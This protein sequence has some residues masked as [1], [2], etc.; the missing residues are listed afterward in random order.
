[1]FTDI[2]G[3]TAL[4][5]K[6]EVTAVLWLEGHRKHF[7]SSMEKYGGKIV[8]FYGDGSLSIFESAVMAVKSAIELQQVWQKET[9]VP[10][11]IGMHVG[12]I[13]M[14]EDGIIGDA[15]NIASRIESLA[16][17]GSILISGRLNTELKNQKEIE[18]QWFGA[19]EFKNVEEPIEVFAVNAPGIINPEA[20]HPKAKLKTKNDARNF[21][22]YAHEF[23]GREKE[24]RELKA[25][26]L[27]SSHRL[28]TILGAGGLGKTRLA[29]EIGRIITNEFNDG[30][31]YVPLDGI[32]TDS[33]IYK[34]IGS[35]LGVREQDKADWRTKTVEFLKNLSVLLV[36]DNFEHLLAGKN[37]VKEI[38]DLCPYLKL[39]ITSR[40]NLNLAEE[41]EFHLH[42]FDVPEQKLATELNLISQNDSISLFIQ[43]A[44]QVRTNFVLDINNVNSIVMICRELEGVPLAI[45]LAA[46]RIK[47]FSPPQILHRLEDLF[48]LLKTSRTTNQK[49]HQ[50]IL[51]TIRWSY[52]LLTQEDQKVFRHFSVFNVGFSLDAAQALVPETD[53][54]EV[55][56]SLVN[57]S[58]LRID[59]SDPEETRFAML[60]VIREFGQKELALYPSEQAKAENA[61]TN[62]YLKFLTE[63]QLQGDTGKTSHWLML[64]DKEIEHIRYVSQYYLRNNDHRLRT[65]TLLHWRYFLLKGFLREGYE[66][67]NK[68]IMGNFADRLQGQLLVAMGAFS[69]NLG[70]F[71]DARSKF[72]H[73]LSIFIKEEDH[74]QTCITLNNLAWVEFRLGN[75]VK[76]NSYAHDALK[77]A[78]K[79]HREKHEATALNNYAWVEKFRGNPEGA[80]SLFNQV[81]TFQN[82]LENEH[83]QAFCMVNK[84]W[85]YIDLGQIEEAQSTIKPAIGY[86]HQVGDRQLWTFSKA[87]QSLLSENPISILVEEIIPSF[88]DIGD[89]W[90][91]GL[92]QQFLAN[93]FLNLQDFS[94]AENHIQKSLDI[95][96]SIDDRWG[97]CNCH[98]IKAIIYLN[99]QNHFE[100]RR[101]LNLSYV[102]AEQMDAPG[103]LVDIISLL[104]WL[105]FK[106]RKLLESGEKFRRVLDLLHH[107]S[108]LKQDEF[109]IKY[110]DILRQLDLKR[111]IS[112]L[113]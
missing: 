50:A 78:K 107:V 66:L 29:V 84:A 24:I 43:K 46:S 16:L 109:M 106:E 54:M 108:K 10:V 75:F 96:T 8:Q 3:Y 67:T 22:N 76:S 99:H 49:R 41:R 72:S 103:L 38:L 65:F 11:R 80:I 105:D 20:T 23:V 37:I 111:P 112:R 71:R 93:E 90:G 21:P 40:S 82:N 7:E 110:Q 86:F 39:I 48:S 94:Q 104:A 25:L 58:L 18:T 26:L 42:P 85:T 31:Y 52:D 77:L 17:S 102:L 33:D 2:E 91:L 63:N 81:Y 74:D 92:A 19:F 51:E 45:E 89:S 57:N 83:A 87:V 30:S 88:N 6:D 100:A 60:R 56:E 27:Q 98:L 95:R 101:H 68:A 47:I 69:Q 61:Y 13:I 5:Q 28:V 62:Y 34:T 73:A 79:Y 14:H 59:E 64:L 44:K 53:A 1:M 97:I 15:V 55:V 9:V 36:L 70:S 4:M 32:N 12:E 113:K 35:V